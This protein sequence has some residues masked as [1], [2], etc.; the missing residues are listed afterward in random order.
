[1]I[2]LR[3]DAD[4][5]E[6]L[7]SYSEKWNMSQ[8]EVVAAAMRMVDQWHSEGRDDDL[9]SLLRKVRETQTGLDQVEEELLSALLRRNPAVGDAVPAA[10][11]RRKNV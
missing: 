7:K 5:R 6:H 4:T 11:L 8:A 10:P 9:I 2:S 1:M 3:I